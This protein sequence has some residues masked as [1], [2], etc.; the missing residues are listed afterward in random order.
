[1]TGVEEPDEGGEASPSSGS[2]RFAF[3]TLC[4][5]DTAGRAMTIARPQS[6]LPIVGK[7]YSTVRI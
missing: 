1:M 4:L 7:Y 3:P 2:S 6:R 5:R